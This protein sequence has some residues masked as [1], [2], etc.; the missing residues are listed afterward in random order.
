MQ[1]Y[2]SISVTPTSDYVGAEVSG[3]DLRE[4]PDARVVSE[5]RRAFAEHGVLFFRD[6]ELSPEQHVAFAEL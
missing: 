3:I 5:L 6:Q 4:K 2:E 1:T